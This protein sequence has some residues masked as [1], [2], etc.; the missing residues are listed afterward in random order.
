MAEFS[1]LALSP[2]E[3]QT[4]P[5]ERLQRRAQCRAGHAWA[6]PRPDAP[7]LACERCGFELSTAKISVALFSEILTD[8]AKA[9]PRREPAFCD[10]LYLAVRAAIGI[11]VS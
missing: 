3:S 2:E 6:T 11:G 8:I 7:A 1:P 4:S 9:A 5:P 10:A